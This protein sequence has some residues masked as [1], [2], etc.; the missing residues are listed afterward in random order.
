MLSIGDFA[1][2]GQVSP[3]MLRHYDETGLLRPSEVDPQTGYRLYVV[4]SLGR[5]HRLLALR[6][7][8]FTLEQIR[9]LL[10]DDVPVEQLR[11]MLRL[12]RA[13]IEQNV[14][15]EQARLRRVEAHLRALEG[16]T[17]MQLHDVVIKQAG[18]IRL[19]EAV[20]TA[21][22]YGAENLGP[23]FARLVPEVVE[24]LTREGAKPGILV[25]HYEGLKDDGTVVLHAG[26]DIGDQDVSSTEVVQ[27]VD[28][29]AVQV[30]S[31]IHRGAMEGIDPAFEA[32]VRWIEDSGYRLA[33]GSRELYHEFH[34]EDPTRH[35]TELQIPVTS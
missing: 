7:L 27:V 10:E 29:P 12:G 26:F 5:L 15:A 18:S 30:V 19:A 22:G 35:V 16:S 8:G 11:G 13:Q 21:P 9:P 31:V 17:T 28:L 4:A 6:D 14:E 23:L 20:G 1:R 32:L 3:R 25:G 24:H 2:L 34:E 33:G